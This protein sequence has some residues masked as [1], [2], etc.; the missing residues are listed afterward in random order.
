MIGGQS[1]KSYMRGFQAKDILNVDR[2]SVEQSNPLA[3][4]TAGRY[5]MVQGWSQRGIL[6]PKQEF[7]FLKTGQIDS[8][9]EDE[10][11][12]AILVREENEDLKKGNEPPVLMTDD[13]SYHVQEHNK[14]LSDPETRMNP[15][16]V[17]TVTNHM[18]QHI[19]AAKS[20]DP[21]LAAMLSGQPLPSM[22]AQPMGVDPNAP[23][24]EQVPNGAPL[25]N[26]PPG[27]PPEAAQAYAE[28]TGQ[29]P[30]DVMPQG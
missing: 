26:V 19:M 2:I 12:D 29:A 7:E 20:M 5:E 1:R 3:Q 16:L 8:I 11:R 22:Q 9:I 28:G 24:P 10:F 14:I 6:T 23:P 15:Q 25:P 27:T 21:D 4:T 18:M 17:E 13:H 30:G